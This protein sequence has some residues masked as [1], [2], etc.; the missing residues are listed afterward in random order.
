MNFSSFQIYNASAGSGKTF[1]LVKEYLKILFQSPFN[2][3]YKNTLAITFT[4]KAVAEM[5]VRIIK[6]L[7]AFS[8]DKIL[9]EPT[10][11]FNFICTELEKS[12][13][14]IHSKAKKILDSIIH[15][16]AAF[17]ISTIDKFTQK[18][19]RTFAYDLH[20]P[21][22][23][24]VELDTDI[25]LS[26]AVNNLIAKAGTN[27]EL[28][29]TLVDFAIE[30]ADDDK[31]WD[32]SFDFLNIAKL[33]VREND[34]RF[35]E[36]IEDKSL[37]D[38]DRLKSNVLQK[39]TKSEKEIINQATAALALI[40]E[41]GLEHGDFSGSYLPKY[42]LKIQSKSLDVKFG[43][44]WQNE[45]EEKPLYPKRVPSEIASIIESIQPQLV[46]FFN[47]SKKH[48]FELSLLKNIYKNLT[49][50][51]VLKQINQEVQAIKEEQNLLLISEFNSIISSHIKNQPAPFIYERIGEK[52]RHYFIDEFQ[53]TSQMQWENLIPLLGNSLSSEN[54]SALIVGDA[55]Q[56]IYR[57]RGGKAEQF[58]DLFSDKNPFHIKKNVEDLPTNYRSSKNVIEFNNSF[59]NHISG[60]ALRDES[61]KRL[62]QNSGQEISQTS[63]G[64]V[65]VSFLDLNKEDD[66]NEAY[67]EQTLKTIQ[68]CIE[69]GYSLNDI[70]ILVRTGKNG[71]LISEYLNEQGIEIISSETLLIQNAP[72]IKFII[73]LLEFISEPQNVLAKIKAL[74]YL[75]TD[76]NN[77]E[78]KHEFYT[79]FK[80]LNLHA[81][82]KKLEDYGYFFN[83]NEFIAL[84][85]YEAIELI[86]Y[87][88][89]LAPESNA[90]IQF[91]LDFVLDFS[92]KSN[93]SIN[94]FLEHFELKKDKLSI[95]TPERNNAVQIMTIHKAKGLEFPVVIF[96]FADL[97]IYKSNSDKVWFPLN[98]DDFND[99][100][101]AL[102]SLNDHVEQ[103]GNEGFLIYNQSKSEKEL[104]NI[105]LLYVALTRAEEQL[106]IITNKEF[107]S[108]GNEKL[109]CY[110]GLFMSYLK[111][112]GLWQ[113][114]TTRYEFGNPKKTSKTSEKG[115]S[116]KLERFISVPKKQHNLNILTASGFLW[117]T[118][119]KEAIEK[120]NLIHLILSKIKTKHDLPFVFKEFL[121]S[122]QITSDQEL[123]LKP[124]IEKV[125]EH[126]NL[127]MYYNSNLKS[128]NEHDI[129]AKSGSII[130]PD[131]L[132]VFP[133]N[134]VVIL[135]YKTGQH[136]NRYIQ[137]INDYKEVIEEMNLKIVKKILVY[138]NDEI[139]VKEV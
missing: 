113:D 96:P 14:Q 27:R 37:N 76:K 49:P 93:A 58:I 35:L 105:N 121:M 69:N 8:D 103:M 118:H 13:R 86:I 95:I 41:C 68:S 108:S 127:K 70:C 47:E 57:W 116:E 52:F 130:R 71:I 60:F 100:K 87:C 128:Y 102:I 22:N 39:T 12:P 4:N 119:Q 101:Y 21:I 44:K 85:F 10:Q 107:D 139:E 106:H 38:F 40:E 120:G 123:F 66:K 56:A 74:S 91:F 34:I 5:K 111:E 97:D 89:K 16:Y 6:N 114:L 30:K 134:E 51:S 92:E 11:M 59:F 55:K 25:L 138:I 63:E 83:V 132:V 94:T 36:T 54:G 80:D 31:S 99:F 2:D 3:T 42:F 53:D 122:G 82:F 62:Y 24:E 109:K 124:L 73:N 65:S 19:I 137:Q 48:F 88:F 17:D 29:K 9:E 75:A 72:E 43:N 33:L 78:D 61:Y 50:L 125:I 84:P 64:Y 15:N 117:D 1:T 79:I 26:K 67:V 115:I 131:K 46:A 23:F 28:T 90:Y 20:L 104:D 45:L 133:N 136:N 7:K 81:Y 126:E 129:L 135:D 18:L 110:S 112:K 77:I 98:S 32:V